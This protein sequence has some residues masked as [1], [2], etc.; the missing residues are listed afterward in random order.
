MWW[1][2]PIVISTA[3]GL[4]AMLASLVPS[5]QEQEELEESNE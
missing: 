4:S 3:V 5:R 2:E 1:V